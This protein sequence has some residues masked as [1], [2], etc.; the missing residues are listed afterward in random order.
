MRTFIHRVNRKLHMTMSIPA[1]V[2][3]ACFFV[4]PIALG[5]RISF[6]DWNGFTPEYEYI[7]FDNFAKIFDDDRVLNAFK[8]TFLFGLLSPLLLC[9][10]GFFYALLLD[11]KIVGR[12]IVR[13]VVY[14]PV[15]I[16]QLI[17]G[18]IWLMLLRPE[19][20]GI[21]QIL[22][23]VGMEGLYS[24]WLAD[25]D[26]AIWAVI[27][28]NLWQFVGWAMIIF[29]AGM[30]SIPSDLYEASR[31]DGA[32]YWQGIRHITIPLL[33]PA[34]RVN[35]IM[36]AIGSLGVFEIIMALTNGGPG[37]FTESLSIYIMRSSF[38]GR[39][40]YATAVAVMM[41]FVVLVPVLLALR[42][43]RERE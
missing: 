36:N 33:L 39:T 3:F 34:T 8:V 20:G 24:N 43:L 28:I 17:M 16:S 25:P 37:Y 32:G 27:I 41:F 2:L 10:L 12:G 7:G 6:T 35:V 29:L 23:A 19:Y 9:V 42:L 38:D 11:R 31:I 14:M 21:H 4:Y 5:I 26:K 13:T 1:V 15:I 18:Y 40:G 30:Q 22:K